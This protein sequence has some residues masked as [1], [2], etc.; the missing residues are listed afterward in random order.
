MKV[1]VIGGGPSGLMCACKASER[2]DVILVE[3]N[4]KVGKKIYITGKGRCNV[5][6]NCTQQEFIINVVTNPKFLY[7]AINN[8]T[9]QDTIEF[10]ESSGVTL[11]TERGNRVFPYSYHASDITKALV[12]NCLKNNVKI[13][14]NETVLDI[15]KNEDKFI[16]K[17]DKRTYQV[18]KVVVATGGLAYPNTGSTG[19]GYKFA[20]KMGIKVVSQVPALVPLLIGDELP[21]ELYNFTFKNVQICAK[22]NKNNKIIKKEFGELITMKGAIGGPIALTVSSIINNF[23]CHDID[24]ELDFKPSLSKETL[25][26]R[27]KRDIE[28]LKKKPNSNAFILVRG[29][30]PNGLIQLILNRTNIDSNLKI[31][32]ITQEQIDKIIDTLKSF[33]LKYL[34]LESFNKAI[35]TKGGIDVKEI[36]PQTMESKKVPGVYFIGEVIDVD[37]YTG[38]FNMQ[39]ALSTGFV[40]GK[41]I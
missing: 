22:N 35:I 31:K 36:N 8:F 26:A 2:H 27:I 10:F 24:L 16:V 13:N 30:A 40:C 21:K 18:D 11:V 28:E 3:K 5:T 7:S 17:T 33:K 4:E 25:D 34:G 20:D 32:L 41:A 14:L 9:S 38:G 1:L 39:I 15:T 12:N 37:A 23:D 6:N 19:D 29:L